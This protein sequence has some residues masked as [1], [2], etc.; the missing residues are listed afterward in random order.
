MGGPDSVI[1]VSAGITEPKK[2]NS[3]LNRLNLYL[4]YGLLGLATLV[5]SNGYKVKLVHGGFSDP[6]DILCELEQSGIIP[7]RHPVML[8][9]PSSYCLEWAHIFSRTL[10][11]RF[12]EVSIIAGGRWV[13]DPDPAWAKKRLPDVDL[14]V[15]GTAERRILSLLG[16]PQRWSAISSCSASLD[17]SPEAALVQPPNLNFFLMD[18]YRDYHPS[19]EMSRGCGFSCSFCLERSVKLQ[20]IRSPASTVHELCRYIQQYDSEFIHP[21]FEASYFRPSRAWVRE[22]EEEY[23]S[24]GLEVTWRCETR[25][26]SWRVSD[27]SDLAACGLKVIDLGLESGS[28]RQLV[29]MGKTKNP[30]R[31]L[32]KANE[33]LH[34]C[35]DNGIWAKVNVLLYAGETEDTIAETV[36]W[37]DGR[38]DC[39]KGVSVTPLIVYRSSGDVYSYV[40]E[41]SRAGAT[42]VDSER[43]EQDGY[44]FVHLNS[45][46]P[47]E[48]AIELTRRISRRYMSDQDYFSLKKFSYYPRTFSWESFNEILD[49]QPLD[50]LPFSRPTSACK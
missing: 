45:S 35:R 34:A 1:F 39:I 3:P 27:I 13:I 14:F 50:E 42:L 21:Y 43:L 11:E 2:G 26:D 15:Y 24:N 18:D 29:A 20:T 4:N 41:L 25:V 31:Y 32:E 37:L 17:R 5:E 8:S 38:R 44:S 46:I 22:F 49:S 16:G 23:R 12:P 9:L 47:H 48:Q 36:Q 40:S 10:K 7:T 28:P 30:T 19:L 33:L 6:A